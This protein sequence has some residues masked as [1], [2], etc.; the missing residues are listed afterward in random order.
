MINGLIYFDLSNSFL[1]FEIYYNPYKNKSFNFEY[2]SKYEW[3]VLCL[4]FCFS[5][6][7]RVEK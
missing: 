5:Y 2:K 3:L 6:D 1:E 7:K 4:L